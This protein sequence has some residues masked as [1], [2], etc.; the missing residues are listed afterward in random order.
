MVRWTPFYVPPYVWNLTELSYIRFG[1]T[2]TLLL[3]LKHIL[4]LAAI[5]L[6]GHF[7]VRYL[8]LRKNAGRDELDLRPFAFAN[9]VLGLAVGYVMMIVLLLHEGVDHAL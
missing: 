8:K 3:A 7:T 2:Y 4:V 9:C 6:A 1:R 5:A